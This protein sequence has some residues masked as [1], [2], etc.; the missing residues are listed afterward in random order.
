MATSHLKENLDRIK[1]EGFFEHLEIIRGIERESLRV[2]KNNKISNLDHPTALGSAL[3]SDEITTDFAEALMELVTPT[4]DSR[5]GL[6]N[7][8]YALHHF[9]NTK[10]GDEV[11]WNFSMPC[12]FESNAEIRLAE[13]G[14]SNQGRIKNIYRRGLKERYGSIM[15]C[16]SGIH[17]NF[18]LSETSIEKLLLA[19]PSKKDPNEMY[20]GAIRNIKRMAP[21]LLVYFGASPIC[22][23]SYLLGR[24]HNLMPKGNDLYLPNATTLRMSKIGYQSPVQE[25]LNISYNDLESFINA[26]IY[27]ITTPHPLFTKIG[28]LDKHG[29]PAQISDGILQIENELY[30]IVRPKRKGNKLDRPVEL[31][32]NQGIGYLEIRGIDI[33]PFDPAGISESQIALLDAFLLLCLI[34]TSDKSSEKELRENIHNQELVVGF[35]RDPKLKISVSGK[36]ALL[37]DHLAALKDELLMIADYVNDDDLKN[38]VQDH[39]ENQFISERVL[40]MVSKGSFIDAAFEHS[41][42]IK[43]SFKGEYIDQNNFEKN[44]LGSLNIFKDLDENDETD[45]QE[46]VKLYNDKIKEM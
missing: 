45:I 12:A 42:A 7:Y 32:K 19:L 40:D 35:G 27:G 15:Q 20:L 13:Y 43:N 38:A 3:C 37:T 24:S 44:A 16:V 5:K 9:V 21:F 1:S 2:T 14:K 17:Y 41:N 39:F 22:H 30:D 26:L 4:F 6:Y 23:N 8:L 31:L 28:L 11:L 34:K 33:N 36:E 46:F 10:I 29:Y 18:S 25:E